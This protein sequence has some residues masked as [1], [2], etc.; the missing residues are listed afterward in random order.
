MN[1]R[2]M[3]DLI[4][5]SAESVEVPEGLKPEHI[6]EMVQAAGAKHRKKNS[7]RNFYVGYAVTAATV[8]AV[9][10]LALFSGIFEQEKGFL[11]EKAERPMESYEKD[12]AEQGKSEPAPAPEGEEI[13]TGGLQK[14]TQ[15]TKQSLPKKDAGNLYRVAEDY[16][17]VYDVVAN[18]FTYEKYEYLVDGLARPVEE[19]KAEE[20][21]EMAPAD[22]VTSGTGTVNQVDH[23]AEKELDD[24]SKTNVQTEGVDESD[25]VKTDGAYLY[26]VTDN[27]VQII[28]IRQGKL[29]KEAVLKL[30]FE[31]ASSSIREIYVDGAKLLVITDEKN[32]QLKEVKK[33]SKVSEYYTATHNQTILYTYSLETPSNPRLL[34]QV[35]QDGI[36]HTS[37]KIGDKVYLFTKESLAEISYGSD[38]GSYDWVP[39][40]GGETIASDCI[41]IPEKGGNSLIIS[42]IDIDQPKE[43]LDNVMIVN[44]NVEVYVSTQAVYLY[45][46]D[47]SREVTT[48]IAKFSLK[49]GQINAVGASSVKGRVLDTFAINEYQ[50]NLRILTTCSNT[51]DGSNLY[52]LDEQLKLTGKLE[53]I[54]PGETVYAARY[55]GD[56]AYFVTYRNIDPLFAADI[57]DPAD[58]VIVGELKITG[59]SEYLHMWTDG[60]MFGIGYETDPDNGSREGIKL[61]MFDV[62]KPTDLKTK[63][64]ICIANADYSPALDQYKTVLADAN[65]NLIGFVVTEYS[66]KQNNTYLLFEWKDGKFHNL[67]TQEITD[68]SSFY[69]GVYAGDY[70]YIITSEEVSAYD[71]NNRYA[72][73]GELAF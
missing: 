30:P 20:T 69:R 31:S 58:P 10:G 32:T 60:T 33:E 57:S 50:K 54:A 13:M 6:E 47:W 19:M 52:I 11:I 17:Q 59:Y 53:G 7:R 41:Y 44:N 68:V 61:S 73:I 71:R 62:S 5:K 46:A 72:K 3:R 14:A 49:D 63:D 2:Q 29:K 39:L 24:F 56:M 51:N 34:G 4:R 66:K 42:S 8:L 9:C 1:D 27:Q 64:S 35:G 65:A 23:V 36:Y 26:A 21:L 45:H 22:A 55:L 18:A 25:I 37:R 43:L 67:L 16:E 28:D 70:F 40:A 15:E 12:A 38:R 48:E